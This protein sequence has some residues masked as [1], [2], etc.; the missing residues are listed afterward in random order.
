MAP[1][2]RT[3]LKL[4]WA[5]QFTENSIGN[6]YGYRVHCEETKKELEKIVTLSN[7]AEDSLIITAPEIYKQRI[8]N[9]TN[10]LFTMFEGTTLPDEYVTNIRQADFLI[11][12]SQWVKGM[13][14]QYFDKEKIFVVNHGISSEFIYKRRKL[15]N[16]KPFRY[17]WVGA[18]NP[19]KGW[20]ETIYTW[21][22]GGFLNNPRVE[23]YIKTTRIEGVQKKGNIILDGRNLSRKDLIN[24]YHN[25]HCFLFPTRGEG[26]GLTLAE[27][28]RTGLPCISTN[29]SGVT[30][31][32]DEKV[33][34]PLRYK[35]D[36]SKVVFVGDSKSREKDLRTTTAFPSVEELR[37]WMVYIPLH[38]KEAIRKAE[39]ASNRIK[40]FTWE[41]AARKLTSIIFEVTKC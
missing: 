35:F 11:T 23:L 29:Y 4:H 7:D 3:D 34:Y 36:E 5:S 22:Y 39:I 17:L 19:R 16:T 27:A 32:F 41:N 21:T 25:S 2:P 28:M 33:G 10:Y 37:D 31:F 20:E 40:R 13:L 15:P 8:S 12:P 14:S 26:F 38:Y 9:K 1:S 24:L 30:D 18:P 6:A